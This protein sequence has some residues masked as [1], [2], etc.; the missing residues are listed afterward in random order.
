MTASI[1]LR[2][3]RHLADQGGF[4]M[5]VAMGVMLV[6]SL[7][8][9]ATF[10]ALDG[11]AHLSQSDL[12]AKRAY[13][14]A[15]AGLNAYLYQLNTDSTYWQTCANDS[16]GGWVAVPGNNTGEY[17]SY[18]PEP[19]NGNTSC[20]NA[21]VVNSMI[22]TNTGGL[23]MT[24]WGKSGGGADATITRGIVATFKRASPLQ[25]L[26]Y[27]VYEA[28]DNSVGS[29]YSQCNAWYRAHTRPSQCEINW[30]TGDHV[31]GPMYTQDQ[32]M[33]Q[34]GNAPVFGRTSADTI[35]TLASSLCDTGCASSVFNGTVATGVNVPEPADNSGLLTD[36]QNY[37]KVFTGQT[38]IALSGS[39]A[40]VTN[41]PSS[42][43]TTSVNLAQYPIIYVQN[44][45]ACP[46]G[47]YTPY[48]PTYPTSSC[49]GDVYISGNYDSSLTVASANNIVVTGDVTTSSSGSTLTGNAVLGLVANS[50]VR[51]QHQVSAGRGS[52]V[53]ACNGA[54]NTIAQNNPTIDAAILALQHSFI[55]D[56]FDCGA[57]MG[58]LTVNGALVQKFR[59]PV[60]TGGNSPVTGYL[61]AYTYDD[62]LKYLA[63]PYLFDILQSAWQLTRENE[64]VVNGTGSQ[65]C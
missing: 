33:V 59:G 40:T 4:T 9:A 25:Y 43:T 54:T 26:W 14:A 3:R 55:V 62:R 31:N 28:F 61:K 58:S 53:G 20:S 57:T 19:A 23:T 48:G 11:E 37:G 52:S 56:N 5:I 35:A 41:C 10:I 8:I 18:S 2:L 27:T 64:C 51:V 32:L 17:Y 1:L 12:D 6:T 24:F 49:L 44:G 50:F 39:T 45:A 38:T 63:P 30:V 34:S 42:C 36:A 15:Q 13:Y 7:L 65:A 29:T 21:N 22:D 60:G 16:S 47:T 46:T